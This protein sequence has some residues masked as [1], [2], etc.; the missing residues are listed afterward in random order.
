ML[1]EENFGAIRKFFRGQ[2]L[3]LEFTFKIDLSTL[4]YD[5]YLIKLNLRE[6]FMWFLLIY[7]I[8]FLIIYL[9]LSD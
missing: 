6:I 9:K 4:N 7:A 2:N 3:N 8:N 5:L 1:E